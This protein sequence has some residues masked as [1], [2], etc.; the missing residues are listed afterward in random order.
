MANA[1]QARRQHTARVMA[2]QQAHVD[3]VTARVQGRAASVYERQS[4]R[5]DRT[6]IRQGTRMGIAGLTGI[7]PTTAIAG[8]IVSGVKSLGQDVPPSIAAARAD[9][10]NLYYDAA[11]SQGN[12]PGTSGASAGLTTGELAVGVALLAVVGYVVTRPS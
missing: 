8:D 6:S 10:Q 5:T 2:R 12:P 9:P 1:K 7:D 4:G 3:A 11:A